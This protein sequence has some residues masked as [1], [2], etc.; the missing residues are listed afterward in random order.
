MSVEYYRES[1]GKFDSRTLSRKSLSRWT[2]RIPRASFSR[3]VLSSQTPVR[4]FVIPKI[5]RPRIFESEL[6]KELSDQELS[7]WTGRS[8]LRA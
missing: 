4:L 5:V 2:G 8:S 1:P 6:S 7:R 3:G